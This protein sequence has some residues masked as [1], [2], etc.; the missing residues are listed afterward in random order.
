MASILKNDDMIMILFFIA[1]LN[2]HDLDSLD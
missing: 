1:T 2:L